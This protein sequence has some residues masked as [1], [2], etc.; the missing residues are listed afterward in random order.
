MKF[1]GR[2]EDAFPLSGKEGLAL[3]LTHVE[4]IP[5]AGMQISLADRKLQIVEVGKNSTD[6]KP[7][8]TR[9]CLTGKTVAPYSGV[10]VNWR[11]PYPDR[12]ALCGVWV[13]GELAL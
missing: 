1:R 6:S 3:M 10:F 8:S 9:S 12:S 7:V 4:G 13:E 5:V 2:I 11:P